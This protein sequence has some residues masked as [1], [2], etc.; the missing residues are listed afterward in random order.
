MS[1]NG[2]DVGVLN[3]LHSQL[4]SLLFWTK[5]EGLGRQLTTMLEER[6]IGPFRLGRWHKWAV[7]RAVEFSSRDG[8]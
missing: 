4:L 6:L 1:N 5:A 7:K 3:I 8:L 2:G